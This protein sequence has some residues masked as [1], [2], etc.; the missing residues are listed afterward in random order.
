MTHFYSN[1]AIRFGVFLIGL[2]VVLVSAA[3]LRFSDLERQPFHA[4]EAATGGQALAYRLESSGGGYA[5]DPKHRH[6]P[7]LTA[8][9]EPWARAKGEDRWELLEEGTL[10]E[11][12]AGCG[13]LA[14][15]GAFVLGMGWWRALIAAGLAGTS[16]LLV[17]YSR[18]FI[19]EPVFLFF[20]VPAL[21]GLIMIFGGRHRWLGACLLG[22]GVGLMAATRETVV[23]SLMAWGLAGLL[24]TWRLH[25]GD[26]T[27]S[28]R[29][30]RGFV[31]G[32][33]IRY[34]RPLVLAA[35]LSLVVIF[36][37][38]SS[39]GRRP[40]GFFD[41][42]STYFEYETGEG[43]EKPFAYYFHLLVWPKHV[44]GWWWTEAGVLLLALCVYLDRGKDSGSATGRFLFEA[45][46]LH[47]FV[48]SLIAYKTPWLASLGWL[49]LCF[50]GGYGGVALARRCAGWGRLV[51]V[52][53]IVLVAFWQGVQAKRGAFR[54]AGDGRNPYAYV[55]TSGDVIGLAPWLNKL[56]EAM[57]GTRDEPIMVIGEEYWPLPWYLREAGSAGYWAE[58]PEDGA[59]YPIVI[60]MP[61]IF[62]ESA[63]GLEG[64][65]TFIPRGLRDE[66]P[67]MV[68]VRN[69]LWEAYQER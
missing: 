2:A 63:V 28:S 64:T 43:H 7:L 14:A 59:E 46:V 23:V 53:S 26:R 42:F 16:P 35:L 56:R 4:D 3:W 39:G 40:G 47:L 6:G 24:F 13:L 58:I 51:V 66:F 5:F 25:R 9:A 44:V 36:W 62:E 22:I 12:V 54:L 1:P 60:I 18:I 21:A 37:F 11:V 38:Y 30:I 31:A 49:H 57:P 55:S 52:A 29:E 61:T 8:L 34:G 65:H 20:A 69:D 27:I 32:L 33:L 48:F 50:A 41:F 45:G 68:G 67:V 19:H 10:R 17:Y 15:L